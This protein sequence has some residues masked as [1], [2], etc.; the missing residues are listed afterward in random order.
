MMRKINCKR[1]IIGSILLLLFI[2]SSSSLLF[3]A[4]ANNNSSKGESVE[5]LEKLKL[6]ATFELLIGFHF[7][8][9]ASIK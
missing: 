7:F 9:S 3:S 2:F 5:N 6:S 8:Y 1:K 4:Q